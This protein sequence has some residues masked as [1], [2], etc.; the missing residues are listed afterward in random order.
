MKRFRRQ[1]QTVS[2]D[3][4]TSTGR[5]MGRVGIGAVTLGLFGATAAATLAPGLASA[6]SPWTEQYRTPGRNTSQFIIMNA[7]SDVILRQAQIVNPDRFEQPGPVPNENR[8][9]GPQSTTHYEVLSDEDK[10]VTATIVYE[11]DRVT[12]DGSM[13]KIG[14][15]TVKWNQVPQRDAPDH[16]FSRSAKYSCQAAGA[17]TC[18]IVELTPHTGTDYAF[19]IVPQQG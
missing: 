17:M 1:D 16:D 5:R 9:L 10:P 6:A 15:V 19:W 8:I 3:T 18:Q 13:Q 2:T 14:D 4:S 12:K 11:A 7:S